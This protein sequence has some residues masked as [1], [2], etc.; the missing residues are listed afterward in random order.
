MHIS[1]SEILLTL[2][3]AALVIRPEHLPGLALKAG[4]WLKLSR[5]WVAKAKKALSETTE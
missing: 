3:I 2:L 4:R 1:L 5:Q